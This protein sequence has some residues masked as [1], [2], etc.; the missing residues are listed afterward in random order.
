MGALE[1]FSDKQGPNIANLQKIRINWIDTYMLQLN[2]HAK[3]G[4]YTPKTGI[5]GGKKQWLSCNIWDLKKTPL[6]SHI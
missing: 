5:W 3:C 1:V 4:I 6:K 2:I